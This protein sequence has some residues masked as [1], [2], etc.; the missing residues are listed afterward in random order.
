MIETGAMPSALLGDCLT[1]T[2]GKKVDWKY[3][4]INKGGFFTMKSRLLKERGTKEE[5][6]ARVL[7]ILCH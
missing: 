7:L 4:F 1:L 3:F 5:P 2:I 6:I